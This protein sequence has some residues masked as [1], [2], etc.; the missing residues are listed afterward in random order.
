M[1][2]NTYECGK[3]KKRLSPVSG[4]PL[5]TWT[6]DSGADAELGN[7][8]SFGIINLYCS[9]LQIYLPAASEYAFEE[10]Q[11]LRKMPMF[12]FFFIFVSRVF[13][14]F[15]LSITVFHV[16]LDYILM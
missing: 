4:Q 2:E 6:G 3:R 1:T 11:F 10:W 14:L 5:F 13:R 8:T 7:V 16:F 12:F 9:L 15:E